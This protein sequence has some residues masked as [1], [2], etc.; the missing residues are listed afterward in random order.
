[1]LNGFLFSCFLFCPL[2]YSH[3]AYKA[4]VNFRVCYGFVLGFCFGLFVFVFFTVSSSD[5]ET[6]NILHFGGEKWNLE[7]ALW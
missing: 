1:M 5:N 4:I 7:V 2:E 3:M 6:G